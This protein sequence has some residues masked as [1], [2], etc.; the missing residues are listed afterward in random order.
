MIAKTRGNTAAFI[1]ERILRDIQSG[2]FK[3]AER[4]TTNGLAQRYE[5]SRTPVREALI[6]LA[7]D[8]FVEATANAG[9]ELRHTTIQEL[10]DVYELR[11][12]LEGLA[13]E[14]LAASGAAPEL[15]AELRSCCRLRREAGNFHDLE[16]ADRRFHQL[17]CNSCG[18]KKLSDLIN[19]NLI[20]STIFN[21]TPNLILPVIS[22]RTGE[23]NDEHDRIVDAIGSGNAKQANRLMSHHIQAA[24]R[25]FEKLI[26]K[27]SRG[28]RNHSA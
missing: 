17:I 28:D 25:E 14:K 4:L 23:V 12:L 20:L 3:P 1:R 5:V 27:Q 8:G 10:C 11:A 2:I 13:A 24:R 7:Q 16:I 21:T 18:S 6:G 19:S 22:K 26:K 9:Y 15:V